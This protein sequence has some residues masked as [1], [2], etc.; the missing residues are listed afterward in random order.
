MLRPLDGI[1]ISGGNERT[2]RRAVRIVVT[3][4]EQFYRLDSLGENLPPRLSVEFQFAGLT[5]MRKISAVDDGVG[6]P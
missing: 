2:V 5:A 4:H 6:I 1:R 3:R